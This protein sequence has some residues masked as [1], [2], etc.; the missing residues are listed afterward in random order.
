MKV[1]FIPIVIGTL[2]TVKRIGTGTWG[3]GNKRTSRENPN[4]RIIKIGQN[5]LNSP[6]DLRR[7]VVTQTS[8]RN[9]RL[10]LV[11]KTQKGVTISIISKCSKLAQKEYKTRL[12][13]VDKVIQWEF[14]KKFKSYQ[15]NKCY[16]HS[17]ETVMENE[18]HRLLWDFEIRT[19]H[20]IS[21]RRPNLA[22]TNK[23]K[24]KPAE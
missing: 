2:G 10:T 19:D 3:L 4:D 23:E 13:C 7:L 11:W 22:M 16:M 15:T 6:G 9:H 21:A 5:I 8:V 17:P 14:S 18:T 20:L 12:D 1:T 24:E